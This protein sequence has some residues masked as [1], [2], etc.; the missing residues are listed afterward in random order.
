[1]AVSQRLKETQKKLMA[2]GF[3]LPKFGADGDY[4][5]EVDD[6]FNAV[7]DELAKRRI[8]TVPVPVEPVAP[9]VAVIPTK[10]NRETFYSRL[11]GSE[12]FP[13]GFTDGQVKGLNRLLDV[14]EEYMPNEPLD[15]LAYNL[16]TSYHETDKTLQPIMEKGPRSYFNKYEPGTKLGKVLGN[17]QIG[18]GYRFRGEGDVQ[19]TGRRNAK[20]ASEQLNKKFNL[21]IDLVANPEKRGDPLI[22]ALSLF[23]GNAEGWW[24]GKKLGDYIDGVTETEAEDHAEFMNGRRVV[25][26]TDKAEKIADH[27]IIF[28][29]ALK[30]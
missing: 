19:N 21:N 17:T 25:N 22:S 30:P 3:K 13:N 5:K 2:M 8:G 29:R 14:W 6:V 15:M 26:G 16:A 4:G 12:I 9:P 1:M 18:D 10:I 27:A 23:L 20:Y 7:L 11:R 28:Q 24:T